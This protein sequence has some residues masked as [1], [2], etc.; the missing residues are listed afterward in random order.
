MSGC[1]VLLIRSKCF[2]LSLSR[3]VDVFVS[4][5]RDL[6]A[7]LGYLDYLELMVLR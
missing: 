5:H 7:G 2:I 4:S 1:L 6:R 3:L